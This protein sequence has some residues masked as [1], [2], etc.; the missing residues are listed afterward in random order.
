MKLFSKILCIVGLIA[1]TTFG[2]AQA[3]SASAKDYPDRPVKFIVPFPPGGAAD[4]FAR[5]VAQKLT[6][7]W[8]Q[9]VLVENKPGAGGRI[10]TQFV[11]TAPADGYTFLVVTVGHAVNPSLYNNLPYKTEQD[12]KT[13]AMLADLPSMLVVNNDLPVSNVKELIAL[14]KAQ[15]GKLTYASSGNATTSHVAAAMLASAENVNLV[16]IPYKGSAPAITDMISGRVNIMIDPI[17]TALPHV[18]SGKLKAL[19]VSTPNRS[20]LVP[21]LPTIAESGVP[22]YD[23]S[24]WFLL[25][26]PSGVPNNLISKVNADIVDTMKDPELLK[27]YETR[28]AQAGSGTPESLSK[29]L[30]NE[31]K[32]FATLVEKTGMKAE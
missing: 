12:F 4:V 30:T 14:A 11:A 32:R 25:L 5:L 8:K 19:A 3:Q 21:Q 28:G 10:A 16:H 1:A 31:I 6:D 17:A 22:G 13:V 15:P 18:K 26:A 20:P 7:K 29:F 2:S 27:T 23:F 9:T 24:A